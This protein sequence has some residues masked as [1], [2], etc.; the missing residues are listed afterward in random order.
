VQDEWRWSKQWLLNLGLRYDKHSD[1]AG[2]TSPRASLIYH[3]SKDATLKAMVGSAY[4]AP[5]VYE[6][7]YDDGGI[8]Q[9]AN[10]SLQPEYIRSAELAADFRFGQG[11][12]MGLSLYRNNMRNMIDQVL[13]PTDNMQVFVNQS[14]AHTQGVELDADQHWSSGQRLRASLSRQWS[15]A[16]DGSELGNSPHWLGKLVFAQP[17]AVGWTMAGEWKGMSERQALVGRVAGFGVFNLTLTS[18]N[19]AHLGEFSLGVYNLS[20][21]LYRDPAS[22]AF[23]QNALAQDGR[24]FRLSWTIH[25]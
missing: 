3:V 2:I 11:G 17:L 18:P 21:R 22:S 4:R 1:Y 24:Q 15:S 12:R 25:L 14:S 10:P 19:L 7:F 8:L 13:D 16:A 6:R 5:N 23:T 9:K 20:D